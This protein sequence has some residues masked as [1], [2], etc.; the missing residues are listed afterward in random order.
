MGFIP[1]TV[2]FWRTDTGGDPD[3]VGGANALV[4]AL[5]EN[6]AT[7]AEYE[8]DFSEPQ[9]VNRGTPLQPDYHMKVVT[10][11]RRGVP[12]PADLEFDIPDEGVWEAGG[13]LADF[14]D[15]FGVESI[16]RIG[17]LADETAIARRED[18]EL[19]VDW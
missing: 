14:L 5:A 15:S 7:A 9:L 8:V 17:D 19:T 11:T 2:A 12:D 10:T 16:D 18:G 4:E 6:V 13:E 1:D 3:V